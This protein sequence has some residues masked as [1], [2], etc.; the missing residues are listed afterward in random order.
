MMIQKQNEIDQAAYFNFSNT[1]ELQEI[2]NQN[3]FQASLRESEDI[4]PSSNH[5]QDLQIQ[6]LNSRKTN[7][8]SV[9]KMG[10]NNTITQKKSQLHI[11]SSPDKTQEQTK[12]ISW[13][14]HKK[15][16]K[17]IEEKFNQL[18]DSVQDTKK[19]KKQW[20][21]LLSIMISQAIERFPKHVDLKIINAY[22]QKSKL[23]NEFKAIFE[24]MNCELC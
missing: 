3:N 13:L 10:K 6:Q 8:S 23:N 7:A 2:S 20:Y 17:N 21:R 18:F 22:I 16:M 19:E 14:Q 15:K 9:H 24:M 5:Q 12:I 1:H 4:M 11:Q